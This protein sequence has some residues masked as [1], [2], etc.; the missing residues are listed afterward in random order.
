MP[1]LSSMV[2]VSPSE[3]AS[4]EESAALDSADVVAFALVLSASSVEQAVRT[5]LDRASPVITGI[6]D[7][8]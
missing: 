5:R 8:N 3:A 7:L 2:M 6:A 1:W 4:D